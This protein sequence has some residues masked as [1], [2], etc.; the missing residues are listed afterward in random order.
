MPSRYSVPAKHRLFRFWMRPLFRGVFHLL[1]QVQIS[2]R[3]NIPQGEAY[4]VVINHVSLYEAPFML[5]FWPEPLEAAGAVEIWERPGQSVLVR[6]YGGIP[7]HRG[8]YD[9]RVVETMIQVLESGYPLLIAPEGARSHQPGMRR[10]EPGCAYLAHRTG[11][12]ILPVGLVGTTD[13]FLKKALLIKRPRLE[14]HIGPQFKL[15]SISAH[16]SER[17]DALQAHADE[18][19]QRIAVLLPLEYQGVYARP[20]QLSAPV[21]QP[22]ETVTPDST[23]SPDIHHDLHGETPPNHA[24]ASLT[25]LPDL[26]TRR[27]ITRWFLRKLARLLVRVLTRAEV[28]GLKHFPRQGAA[29]IVSNHLGDADAVL[30]LAYLP[31]PSD[32][33]AKV[34]L[35]TDYP[36]LGRVMDAYGVI[37]V[38]RGLA[39]Q[40]SDPHPAGA[41]H[42]RSLRVALESLRAG[43]LVGIAPEGRESLTGG[44]E[45]G[46]G[47]AAYLALK[48][49][50]PV[51]PVTFTGTSNDQIYGNLKRLRRT[52]VTMTVGEAFRL[53]RSGDWKQ[54]VQAG[55]LQMMQ[56]L[57]KQLPPTYRGIY[58]VKSQDE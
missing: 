28:K 53:E 37:W 38:P 14:M 2:G 26:N 8:Q 15:P 41:I 19:M 23:R 51:I 3:E 34:D 33:L 56:A 31:R 13:D 40:E 57:A 29:L 48:A 27:R 58:R 52:Q 25:H 20:E 4:L 54:S 9:R 39:I 7:V 55:T 49:D 11:V 10:A 21:S 30:G 44:L 45:A 32:A 24:V 16:G 36:L 50:V 43:R 42:L 47:G 5:A 17:R 12:P 1:S 35:Y 46:M 18:I 22:E 6:L